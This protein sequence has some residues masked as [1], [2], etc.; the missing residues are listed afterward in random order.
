MSEHD[1][2]PVQTY[3]VVW[4][5]G[6]MERIQAHQVIWP[7]NALSLFGVATKPPRVVMHA[8]LDG[9]WT[10]ML[11]APEEDIRSIRNVTA[12][13]AIPEVSR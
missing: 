10:L 9:R 6:H 2:G 5:S 13:E 3:E 8:V 4:Q 11:S 12:D 7:G 1:Y